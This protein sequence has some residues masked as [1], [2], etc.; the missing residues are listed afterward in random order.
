[1]AVNVLNSTIA[2]FNTPVDVVVNA[3]TSTVVDGSEVFTVTPTKQ[4]YKV[5]ITIENGAGQ[6]ALAYSVAAGEYWAGTSALTGSVVDGGREVFVLEGAK[7]KALAGTEAIT[8]TPAAGKFL[9]AGVG[10]HGAKV[11]VVELP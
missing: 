11:T 10:G 9:A 2:K 4:D 7:F 6:G 1:M 3:A 5:A 8:L